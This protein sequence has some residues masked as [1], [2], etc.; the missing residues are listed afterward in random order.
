MVLDCDPATIALLAL[1]SILVRVGLPYVIDL[2]VNQLWFSR[3]DGHSW[4]WREPLPWYP[5]RDWRVLGGTDPR[6]YDGR[7]KER[8]NCD[9]EFH[10]VLI[11]DVRNPWQ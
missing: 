1:D 4:S 11:R 6:R 9:C 8:G 3:W 10:G 7:G 5:W 2:L